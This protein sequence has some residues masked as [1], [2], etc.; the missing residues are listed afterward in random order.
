MPYRFLRSGLFLREVHSHVSASSFLI[1]L[2][3]LFCFHEVSPADCGFQTLPPSTEYKLNDQALRGFL[4]DTN[5]QVLPSQLKNTNV[6]DGF[7]L[8]VGVADTNTRLSGFPKLRYPEKEV[9]LM[10]KCLRASGYRVKTL[11]NS[12]ATRH[13]ILQ[14]L[15]ALSRICGKNR[16][17]FY[18]TGHGTIYGKIPFKYKNGYVQ[19]ILRRLTG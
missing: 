7:A 17:I 1:T 6:S 2:L 12:E 5:Q 19:G 3:I 18:Y 13:N 11:L 10:R 8:L 14:W 9:K 4:E 15:I 16:F